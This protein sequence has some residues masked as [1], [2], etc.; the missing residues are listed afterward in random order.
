MRIN[1]LFVREDLKVGSGLDLEGYRAHYL[2]SVL[3]G[4]PGQVCHVFNGLGG[5]FVA[6]IVSV[7]RNS[8]HLD[9][10]AF[11]ENDRESPL[12][13][14]VGIGIVRS[15][16][17]DE[18]LSHATE[19]GAT[20][21]TPLHCAYSQHNQRS[22]EKRVDHWHQI[23]ISAAEQCG[24]NRLPRLAPVT[25]VN[26]WQ[27]EA[28]HRLIAHPGHGSPILPART[29]ARVALAIGPEG[30]FNHDELALLTDGGFSIVNLG[31]RVLRTPT[32]VLSLLALTQSRWGDM[33]AARL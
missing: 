30:G 22:L 5:E 25:P 8:I 10:T 4:R 11:L 12:E 16:A 32:A 2:R 15:S 29:P 27:V 3:R 6:T 13:T 20:I 17:M 7:S 24:R 14:H 18:S 33:D 1:R 19:L 23:I 9:L 26:T 31:P 28:E 21:I